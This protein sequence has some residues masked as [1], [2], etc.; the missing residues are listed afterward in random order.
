MARGLVMLGLGFG[1]TLAAI[2]QSPPAGMR[3]ETIYDPS[4]KIKAFD[5]YVPDRWH[6]AGTLVQG[7]SCTPIAFPVFRAMSPDGLTILD[8]FPRLDWKWT[9]GHGP[10]GRGDCLPLA[11]EL[12][13]KQVLLYV[14]SAMH[15][16]YVRD[17]PFPP[18][19]LA[20]NH[21]GPGTST[22]GK[23]GGLNLP[24]G[25]TD[26]T[27]IIVS[28]RNGSF[29]IK[30]QLGASVFCSMVTM[31]GPPGQPA[32]KSHTCA[33]SLRLVRAPE[34]QFDAA[35]SMLAKAGAAQNPQWIHAWT[36]RINEQMEALRAAN[37]AQFEREQAARQRMHEE[38]MATMQRGT[39][40][41]MQRA[42]EAEDARSAA[43]QNWCDYALDQ[44]S[45]HDPNSGQQN[46]VSS[47]TTYT[48]TNGSGSSYRTL[49]ADANPNGT[50]GGS[51]RRQQMANR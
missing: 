17:D 42:R 36:V 45:V 51:W 22:G 46:M 3:A 31:A 30:G 27:Q 47:G 38:F 13:A 11:Q 6:F 48:W 14:A 2:A 20:Q 10:E 19:V 21:A 28:Y 43:A 26:M 35:V 40:M 7:T 37:Q 18:E 24:V 41:S 4:L 49:D 39:D 32:R 5:V 25:H 16:Q 1:M 29:T 12:T 50:L 44:Q 23:V 15:M 9:E 33:A 8:R 34:G